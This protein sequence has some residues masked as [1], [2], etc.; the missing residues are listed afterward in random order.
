MPAAHARRKKVDQV[1]V[2]S[3]G[4]PSRPLPR[5]RAPSRPAAVGHIAGAL[6][7][8]GA[9]WEAA[10]PR[11]PWAV[12][13]AYALKKKGTEPGMKWAA[14]KAMM[15][16]IAARPFLSS[17]IFWASRFSAPLPAQSQR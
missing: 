9:G 14:E 17:F 4:A 10:R 11:R 12:A 13:R 7:V 15:P 16:S 5:L 3:G 1:R 2:S 8:C 6:R